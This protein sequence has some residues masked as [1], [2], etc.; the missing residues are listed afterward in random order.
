MR[1]NTRK[2]ALQWALKYSFI[3]IFVLISLKSSAQV[4]RRTITK[5]L[6]V[7]QNSDLVAISPRSFD[8]SAQGRISS[9]M[10]GTSFFIVPGG[11]DGV[12]GLRVDEFEIS[13]HDKQTVL[14]EVEVVVTTDPSKPKDAQKLLDNLE[15]TLKQMGGGKIE[16]DGNL[17]FAKFSFKNGA[18]KKNVNRY[19]LD[20]GS[21]YVAK[22]VQIISKLTIPKRSNLELSSGMA[23]FKIGDL[24]G[25][26]TINSDYGIVKAAS[27]RILEANVRD[28]RID[29][30]AVEQAEINAARSK[31]NI[32]KAGLLTIGKGIMPESEEFNLFVE[33]ISSKQNTYKL[34]LISG[35]ELIQS[36]NDK[37]EIESISKLKVNT[38]TFSDFEIGSL[39][40]SLQINSKNGDLIIKE[41]K[42]SFKR[43]DIDNQFSKIELGLDNT[44][45]FKVEIKKQ[46][47]TEFNVSEIKDIESTDQGYIKGNEP[48]LG[49]I[50]IDCENCQ[51]K[52]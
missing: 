49:Q 2:Q 9:Y 45:A 47:Y 29:I 37:F 6:E 28:C 17:N 5:Q 15:S 39:V 36:V 32:G 30:K 27:I 33:E 48:G 1:K 25:T 19:T 22:G 12:P 20:D 26:L 10:E 16:M 8:F 31:I 14:Q 34:G 35:I 50:K 11:N 4:V 41:T 13:T 23:N 52:F 40:E 43:I 24:D 51:I 18:F 3:L 7:M 21:F 42:A 46:E 38:S 44:P